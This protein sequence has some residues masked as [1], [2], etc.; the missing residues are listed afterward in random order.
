MKTKL[1]FVIP[2]VAPGGTERQL[3]YLTEALSDQFEVR[4]LCTT[5]AGT[6]AWKLP[7]EFSTLGCRGGWDPRIQSRAHDFFSKFRPAIV[8]SFMFGFDYAINVAARRAAVPV[9]VSSRR[10]LATWMR[11]RHIRQ[12]RNA[13]R[14]VD[15]IVVNSNA[16]AHFA[17][18]QEGANE[19]L[20]Q[21]IP[22]GIDIEKF[23][24]A[25]RPEAARVEL[26]LPPNSPVLGM[27]ANFSPVKDHESFVEI[28][29]QFARDR[30][31]V[32]F[33][34]VGDGPLRR[35]TER[36]LRERGLVDRTRVVTGRSD[37]ALCY[38][39]M[40]VSV[41]C[42]KVE[43]FPNAALES[44]AARVPFV[45][46][47]VGGIPE[48]IDDGETGVLIPGRSPKAFAA[49]IARLLEA[50]RECKRIA[51]RA[52]AKVSS[53]FTIRALAEQHANLY[54]RLLRAKLDKAA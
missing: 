8:H 7:C 32:Q 51:E 40:S 19:D 11:P 28:A 20:F 26:G 1:A 13:N 21:V 4:V 46:P 3:L 29:A 45:G 49:A 50:P 24:S 41:L 44:M 53:E 33:L 35:R 54:E 42:S 37:L 34:L 10:E 43:G 25:I 31:D 14:L 18:R 17:C 22:N 38:R 16:V 5:V 36:Q 30:H 6:W 2:T 47:A 9:V 27:V 15:C 23:Q 48:I 52:Y 39:A 12:Q